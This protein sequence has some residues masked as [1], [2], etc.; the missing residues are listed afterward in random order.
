ARRT[1]LLVC[2]LLVIP[3]LLIPGIGSLWGSI[4]II[5]LAC[6]AHQGWASNI[7]TVVSDYYPKSSVATMTSMSSFAGSV[8][9]VL[10]AS[11]VGNV[12]E[13]TGSYFVVFMIAGFAY[14]VAWALLQAFLPRR[15][16][17]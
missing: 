16:R 10:A 6:F 1:G 2:A 12:L 11:F 5:S 4:L 15:A 3:V 17:A 14:L 7:Y 13:I 8:G 9:G